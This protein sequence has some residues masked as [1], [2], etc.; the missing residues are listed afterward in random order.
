M[1]KI[2]VFA[3]LLSLFVTGV[4]FAEKSK[5]KKK[6]WTSVQTRTENSLQVQDFYNHKELYHE[7]TKQVGLW[8]ATFIP[9]RKSPEY[10]YF[11][12]AV[13]MDYAT[14][15]Y[16]IIRTYQADK[17]NKIDKTTDKRFADA[18]WNDISGTKYETLYRRMKPSI[19]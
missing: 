2:I 4:C 7:G 9:D 13:V 19:W 10:S 8:F 11:Y 17:K 18:A 15:K 14:G 5:L 3:M 1:K 12:E 16:R 6:T